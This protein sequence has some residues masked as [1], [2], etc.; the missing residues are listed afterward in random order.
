MT[1]SIVLR[2]PGDV[3]ASLP[4]QLGYHP[5][6]SAVVI[7]LR[8]TRVVMT[9]RVDLPGP[10]GV[11]TVVAAVAGPALR[12]RP[13]SVLL[14]GY[15][16][17]V[18]ESEPLLAALAER[19]G[20]AGTRVLDVVVVRDGRRYSLRCDRPC[21]PPDGIPLP[22]AADVP[23]VAEL[24]ALGRSPLPDRRSVD[25]LVE[26]S[27]PTRAVADRLAALPA[28]TVRRRRA[29]VR[30]W[31]R[32]L[33]TPATAP[34]H[35]H[36]VGASD[37]AVAVRG[38]T[39]VPLRDGVVSWVAPGVLPRS[40]VDARVVRLLEGCL[41]RWGAMGSWGTGSPDPGGRGLVVERLIGLARAVP[42]D[43]PADA[44]AACTVLAQA[45]WHDGDGALTRAALGRA[46]RL[47]PGYRLA[48]LLD[49]VVGAGLRVSGVGTTAPRTPPAPESLAG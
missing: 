19:F 26:P 21:C 29:A 46:L 45:A 40:A 38:L 31:S 2:D 41:P 14:V 22:L 35:D 49:T 5:R 42:D 3:V 44:A 23:A 9:A 25:A 47:D 15:E 36:H 37:V 13:G 39:D 43:R 27:G 10:D 48:L 8:A 4:Y 24:V 33:R 18:G 11:P 28:Q 30:A 32:V 17:H 1:A 6:R 34:P 16:D 20:Q 12:E 7:T